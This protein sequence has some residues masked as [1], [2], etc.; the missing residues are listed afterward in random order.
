MSKIKTMEKDG[1]EIKNSFDEDGRQTVK[2]TVKKNTKVKSEYEPTGKPG[3]WLRTTLI[4]ALP[5]IAP[6]PP[7]P[8]SRVIVGA[9]IK[10]RVDPTKDILTIENFLINVD[11]HNSQEKKL[12][13]V[14][15]QYLKVTPALLKTIRLGKI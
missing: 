9:A 12:S 2:I 3:G 5:T 15:L 6:R 11:K 14:Q 7:N 1:K 8:P 10:S 4:Q 13:S